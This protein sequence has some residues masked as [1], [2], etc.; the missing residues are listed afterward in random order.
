MDKRQFERLCE[1][2]RQ[3]AVALAVCLRLPSGDIEDL[4]QEMAVALC[5]MD[6]Q[7]DAYCIRGAQWAALDWLRKMRHSR[8]G[9]GV[10]NAAD[11]AA[12]EDLGLCKRIWV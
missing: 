9:V 8:L 5:Q 10:G 2:C 6:G 7:S 1:E 12:L 11:L 4:K 3:W